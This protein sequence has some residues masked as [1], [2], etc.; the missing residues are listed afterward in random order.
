M[1]VAIHQPQYLPWVPYCDK[2]DRCD[3][4]VY[5]DNVQ[6]QKNGLQ[7]RNQIMTATGA[8]WLTVPV[9][10]SLS[11]TIAE[12][13]VAD[14]RWRDKH[15]RT[16]EM[17]YSRAPYLN[18]FKEE[19]RP[20]L[21][22]DWELLADLNIS[23]TE[24]MF[25]NMGVKARRIRASELEVSGKAD[26]LVINI[27]LAVGANVYLSGQGARAYQNVKKFQEHG[28]ELQYQEYRNQPYT[29]C[30][31]ELEF[32]PD[33]SALDLILN[34]GPSAREIMLA[35]RTEASLNPSAQVQITP[36]ESK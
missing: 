30:H 23:V 36:G 22:R 15:I 7:N 1:I 24:W 20:L 13:R 26:D 11:T 16:V 9:R 18:R 2:A 33:L 17:S 14:S 12:T 25:E 19:V 27:C 4:F 35:G 31:K 6:Y 34:T 5:L 32:I 3:V 8:S 10:A 29:Q 28:I 21:E